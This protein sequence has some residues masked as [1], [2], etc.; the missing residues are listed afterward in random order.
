MAGT[1]TAPLIAPSLVLPPQVRG[2]VS[3]EL[4]DSGES[5][6]HSGNQRIRGG[7]ESGIKPHPFPSLPGPLPP[8]QELENGKIPHAWATL[9]Q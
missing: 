3:Q 7:G 6:C 8:L 2:E 1:R 4:T 5:R 9:D